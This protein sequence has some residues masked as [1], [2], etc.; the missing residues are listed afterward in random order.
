MG[1]APDVTSI[2][3]TAVHFTKSVHVLAEWSP[4]LLDEAGVFV[5]VLLTVTGLALQLYRPRHQ[6]S[7]EERVKDSKMTEEEA[8]RQMQFFARLVPMVSALG[9]LLLALAILDLAR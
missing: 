4:S 7:V 2:Y 3:F 9:V 6:M 1:G 5:A 8:R